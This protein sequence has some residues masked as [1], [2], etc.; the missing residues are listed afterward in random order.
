MR[1]Q[2]AC[3]KPCVMFVG[4]SN[5]QGVAAL[6][7]AT[8]TGRVIDKL[9]S[10]LSGCTFIKTNL[11]SWAPAGPDGRLRYPTP[12]EIEADRPRLK[13]EIE[14]SRP[15]VIIALGTVVANALARTAGGKRQPRAPG[16]FVYQPMPTPYGTVVAVHHPAYVAVYQRRHIRRYLSAVST[17]VAAAIAAA[18]VP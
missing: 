3:R 16:H 10:S 11:V 5:K 2:V 6:D 15:H 12:A 1:K 17:A 4:I 7:S 14:R 13:S 8:T 18:R 9:A